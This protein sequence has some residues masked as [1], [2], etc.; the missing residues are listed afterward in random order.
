MIVPGIMSMEQVNDLFQASL[1]LEEFDTIGGFVLH[2]FGRMPERG[3]M[4]H[5]ENYQFRIESVGRTRILK[6]RIEK[7]KQ[8]E[9]EGEA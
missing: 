8:T 7:E 3:E 5:F 4:I 2:L 6:I 9:T 1:P